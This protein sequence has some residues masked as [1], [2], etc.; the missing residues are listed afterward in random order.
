MQKPKIKNYTSEVPAA[1]SITR[2]EK[3]LIDAGAS[4]ISKSYDE[5]T[6][7]CNAIKFRILISGQPVFFDLPAKVDKCFIILWNMRTRKTESDRK[8]VYQQA[9]RTAWKIISDWVDIQISMEE[10]DQAELLQVLLPYAYDAT[11]NKTFY[12]RF[13]EDGFKGLLT[14]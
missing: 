13:K 8:V 2:I 14:Q 12:D 9:E 1:N 11:S 5:K 4:D 6:R 3:R 10:L 7:V